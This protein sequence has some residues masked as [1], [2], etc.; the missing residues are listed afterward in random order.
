MENSIEIAPKGEILDNETF[1]HPNMDEML[2]TESFKHKHPLQLPC[3]SVTCDL[4]TAC[5]SW[6]LDGLA[7]AESNRPQGEHHSGMLY[8][9]PISWASS[10]PTHTSIMKVFGRSPVVQWLRL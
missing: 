4:S 9:E 3:S 8:A 10:L 6:V 2:G 1:K 5:L 7:R